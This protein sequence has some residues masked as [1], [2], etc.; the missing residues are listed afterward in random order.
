MFLIDFFDAIVALT[1]HIGNCSC[2]F[3]EILAGFNGIYF[4][5]SNGEKYVYYRQNRRIEKW[6]SDTWKNMEHMDVIY[7]GDEEEI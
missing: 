6:Y 5:M 7:E 1:E 2:C 3:N 4:K